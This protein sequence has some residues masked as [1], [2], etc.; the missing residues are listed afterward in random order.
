MLYHLFDW[1]TNEGVKFPGSGLF[2]FIS[3]RVMLAVLLSLADHNSI[4]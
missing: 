1:L 3:F 4:W 2:R